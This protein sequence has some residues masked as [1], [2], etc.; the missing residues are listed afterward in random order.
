ME[1]VSAKVF[2][3]QSSFVHISDWTIGMYKGGN[4]TTNGSARSILRT[5]QS[6]PLFLAGASKVLAA[7]KVPSKAHCH[8]TGVVMGA[9]HVFYKEELFHC[10]F[11]N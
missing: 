3:D 5:V 2:Q 10:V 6:E 11:F 7:L 4:V 8:V 9:S 1:K